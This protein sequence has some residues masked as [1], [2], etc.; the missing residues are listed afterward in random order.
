MLGPGGP[1][2]HLETGLK[3]PQQKKSLEIQPMP[4]S[5]TRKSC[6]LCQFPHSE[7]WVSNSKSH[8][9]WWLSRFLN[10]NQWNPGF[11]P[12]F[13]W[14]MNDMDASMSAK[15]ATMSAKD[16]SKTRPYALTPRPCAPKARSCAPKARPSAPSVRVWSPRTRSCAPIGRARG[17]TRGPRRCLD[18]FTKFHKFLQNSKNCF[19]IPAF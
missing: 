6:R 1:I 17:A 7:R 11:W 3:E 4:H 12:L 2:P 9:R 15:D 8:F 10:K 19:Q 14:S 13:W 5:Q 16:A 18:F